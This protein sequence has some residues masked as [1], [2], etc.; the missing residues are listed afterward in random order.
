MAERRRGQI[1]VVLDVAGWSAAIPG[2]DDEAQNSEPNW[3]PERI[4]LFRVPFELGVHAPTS[5]KFEEGGKSYFELFG[6]NDAGP[7]VMTGRSTP[8]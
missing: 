1:D 6:S 3:V 2:L 8:S 4:E 7:G 5:N